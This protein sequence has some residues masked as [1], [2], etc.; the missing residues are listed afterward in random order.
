MLT[1]HATTQG[2]GGCY[3][4]RMNRGTRLSGILS[5]V[6]LLGS[7]DTGTTTPT[8]E[9]PEGF[10]RYEA[11][12]LAAHD[13]ADKE[14]ADL[15]L[16]HVGHYASS[17]GF[18]GP[19]ADPQLWEILDESFDG[20][21]KVY[22]S[23]EQVAEIYRTE[24]K[25][26]AQQKTSRAGEIMNEAFA[27]D[28]GFEAPVQFFTWMLN[29]TRS[30]YEDE[31]AMLPFCVEFHPYAKQSNIDYSK[32]LHYCRQAADDDL[33]KLWEGIEAELAEKDERLR[34]V[35]EFRNF[36]AI[37]TPPGGECLYGDCALGW[38]S[39]G[40]TIESKCN[41]E[42]QCLGN[43][44]QSGTPSGIIS[45][46]CAKGGCEKGW[47]SKGAEGTWVAKCA[48]KDDCFA[49]GWTL[50]KGKEAYTFTC[51][52]RG[53]EPNCSQEGYEVTA[54]DSK[55]FVCGCISER[56]CWDK[57]LYCDMAE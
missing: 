52:E 42:H 2:R 44:W 54:P 16:D 21:R 35:S 41:G 5:L 55:V 10:L 39:F 32:F 4:R 56:G 49:E 30:N 36:V 43:G 12:Q 7:C 29:D 48:K 45:T 53:G 27:V 38:A 3:R 46:T 26:H 8:F 34:R 18:P 37:Y 57:G 50:T 11:Q 47:K 23:P 15:Y 13:Y 40:N 31:F 14:A 6:A 1:G 51:R 9:T 17:R 22:D 19:D 25:F 28:S 20:L 24:Y 33:T